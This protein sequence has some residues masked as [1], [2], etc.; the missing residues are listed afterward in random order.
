MTDYWNDFRLAASTA[1]MDNATMSDFLIAGMRKDLQEAWVQADL[2]Q[3]D[4][5]K[6]AMWA[7]NKEA[8]IDTLL[9]NRQNGD[10]TKTTKTNR[11]Q[12][13]TFK[14]SPTYE[15]MEVDATNRGPRLN[16]SRNEYQKRMAQGLCL[17]CGKPGHRIQNCEEGKRGIT[18]RPQWSPRRGQ[19]T[20]GKTPHWKQQTKIKTIEM[21]EEEPRSQPSGNDEC[22]Q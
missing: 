4:V 19:E 2:D 12:D 11:N 17:R 21:E 13:G 18:Q 10:E 5:E 16:I 22:P 6:V 20:K 9:Y 8:R 14:S 15:P 7:I 1:K 3:E